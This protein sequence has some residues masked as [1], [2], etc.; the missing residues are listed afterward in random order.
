MTRNIVERVKQPLERIDRE[1][2]ERISPVHR[3]PAN[4]RICRPRNPHQRIY[5]Q[6]LPRRRVVVAIYPAAHR[7]FPFGAIAHR[8]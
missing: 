4:I 7:A 1:Q 2:A 3:I 8:R 5:T 6:K